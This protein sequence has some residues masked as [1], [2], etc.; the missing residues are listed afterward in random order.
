M[1]NLSNTEGGVK[2]KC[3]RPG[4]LEVH[5]AGWVNFVCI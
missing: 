1:C 3:I 2:E 5:T 4:D